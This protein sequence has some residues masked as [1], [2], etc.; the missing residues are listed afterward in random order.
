MR[1]PHPPRW[2]VAI[3]LCTVLAKSVVIAVLTATASRTISRKCKV[4]VTRAAIA[5]L[6]VMGTLGLAGQVSICHAAD[7]NDFQTWW[8]IS[9]IYKFNDRWR[10]EGDQGTRGIV[11]NEEWT[12][13]YVRPSVRVDVRQWFLLHGGLGLFYTFQSFPGDRFEIRPWIGFRFIWPRPG[14]FVVSHYFRF[15]DRFNYSEFR[16]TWDEAFRG[17]YQLAVKTP[18]FS[19]V[20]IDELYGVAGLEL[21]K[22]LSGAVFERFANRGRLGAGLGKHVGGGLRAELHYFYQS[23]GLFI[24]E[25]VQ[26]DEHILRLRLFY[27]FN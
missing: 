25:G 27:L 2:I 4:V 15:E 6:V 14:G 20:G 7:I 16:S 17:R 10:Y 26:T 5:A 8:D 23:S 24:Q 1:Q 3:V 21:F 11:S 18:V 19:F 12:I 13:A 9:T 22:D